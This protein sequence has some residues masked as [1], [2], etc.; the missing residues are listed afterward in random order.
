V[1]V[2]R[3]PAALAAAGEPSAAGAG[4]LGLQVETAFEGNVRP[5]GYKRAPKGALITDV[6][7]GSPAEDQGLSP[8]LVVTEVSGRPISSAL[9][10]E[11]AVSGERA[12]AGVRLRV[13]EPSG[14][15]RYV[16]LSTDQ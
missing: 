13:V 16:F 10:F 1:V 6:A 12:K 14:G 2:G 4:G 7:P 3:Q 15:A 5:Y 8:G 11:R 9:E